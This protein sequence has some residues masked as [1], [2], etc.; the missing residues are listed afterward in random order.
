MKRQ[1]PKPTRRSRKT[2]AQR[3]DAHDAPRPIDPYKQLMMVAN[4]APAFAAEY[5]RGT[6]DWTSYDQMA[7]E[8]VKASIAIGTRL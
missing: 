5:F 4:L 6:S 3:R 7:D 1:A 2:P 8:L